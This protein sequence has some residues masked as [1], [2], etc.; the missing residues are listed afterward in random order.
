LHIAAWYGSKNV[1]EMLLKYGLDANVVN[2]MGCSPLHE[3]A[4]CN[5]YMVYTLSEHGAEINLRS[6]HGV[7]SLLTA[8]AGRNLDTVKSLVECG[9]DIHARDFEG[10]TP[11]HM[12]AK[13]CSYELVRYFLKSGHLR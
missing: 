6:N 10:W 7:T 11:L 12:A 2:N 8:V 9:A 13:E 1:A 3:A 5:K 4:Y